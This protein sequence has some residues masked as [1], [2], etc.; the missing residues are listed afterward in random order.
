M[1]SPRIRALLRRHAGRTTP[2]I[3]HGALTLNRLVYTS[4]QLPILPSRVQAG[5]SSVD[6]VD[7][8]WRIFNIGSHGYTIQVAQPNG[9]RHALAAGAAGRTM[10]PIV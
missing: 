2:L 9:A 7:N 1:N 6:T 10:V 8:C 5:Y 3:T 4:D